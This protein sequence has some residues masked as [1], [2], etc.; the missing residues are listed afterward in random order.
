M[1]HDTFGHI[2]PLL[3]PEY[4][5]FMHEFGT[6]GW[7]LAKACNTAAL[8]GFQRLYWYFVEFGFLADTEGQPK[9]IGAGIMSSIGEPNH[10]WSLRD[11]S[12]P[13]KL[14]SVM[15]TPYRTDT[16]KTQYVLLSSIEA[17][18]RELG[19]WFETVAA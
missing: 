7:Q 19:A 6:M 16:I 12:T 8:L 9:L 17:M 4:A 14:S 10:G 1:F 5:A 15:N 2:P 3:D 18:R 11:E 13:F